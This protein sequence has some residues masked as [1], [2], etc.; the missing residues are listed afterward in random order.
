L[1]SIEEKRITL[2]EQIDCIHSV[3]YYQKRANQGF[4]L[5]YQHPSQKDIFFAAGG[6]FPTLTQLMH[7]MN[8]QD[9]LLRRLVEQKKK[10]VWS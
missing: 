6:V 9:S 5:L 7:D 10:V 8:E 3:L 1:P 2:P 4:K